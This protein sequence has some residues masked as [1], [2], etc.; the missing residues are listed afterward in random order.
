MG[1]VS[2]QWSTNMTRPAEAG[3]FL[4]L[5]YSLLAKRHRRRERAWRIHQ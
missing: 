4:A 3:L 2:R 1:T 5:A